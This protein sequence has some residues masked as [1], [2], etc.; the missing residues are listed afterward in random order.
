MK[1]KLCFSNKSQISHEILAY[2]IEYPEA[3][4]TFDG[5]VQWWLLERKI[6]YQTKNVKEA[7]A[8][9]VK[10]GFVLEYKKSGSN[11]HYKINKY[12]VETIRAFLKERLDK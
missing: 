8:D 3:Q 4:D 10:K 11:K 12:K 7:L 6:V 1:G 5:I 9:L 2:L